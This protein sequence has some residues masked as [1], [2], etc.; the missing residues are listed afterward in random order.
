M[1]KKNLLIIGLG[2]HG[3]DTLAELLSEYYGYKF[4]SSSMFAA[5][6]FIFDEL[7]DK[8]KYSTF[9]DCYNDRHNHREEWYNLIKNY[10]LED[11][12]RLAREMIEEGYNIYVG[13][14]DDIE[15]E[16]CRKEGL[17]DIIVWVD[18]TV[19]LGITEDLSSCKVTSEMADCVIYNNRTFEDFKYSVKL[20]A[21][22]EL[23]ED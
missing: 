19:R 1:N 2:R 17:F 20:F 15:L 9:E 4:T 23:G 18:A 3:K 5:K 21:E 13:M 16:T 8:Y 6:K 11:P 12:S 14:R 10:N 7:K 22:N